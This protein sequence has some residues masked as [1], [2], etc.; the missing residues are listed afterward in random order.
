M[1]LHFQ[2]RKFLGHHQALNIVSQNL[3]CPSLVLSIFFLEFLIYR[4][5]QIVTELKISQLSVYHLY[6]S[7]NSKI[8]FGIH[9]KGIIGFYAFLWFYLKSFIK[10]IL[11]SDPGVRLPARPPREAAL[12]RQHHEIMLPHQK[13]R[14][15]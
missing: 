3:F 15:L 11:T 4:K 14:R 1:T 5:I 13:C 7:Y 2:V 12:R 8:S 10:L 9:S 6:Y